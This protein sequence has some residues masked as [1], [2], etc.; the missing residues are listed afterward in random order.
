MG[1]AAS[2]VKISLI[3]LFYN[4][5]TAQHK[6]VSPGM[7]ENCCRALKKVV[8]KRRRVNFESH[9]LDGSRVGIS[10]PGIFDDDNLT[11]DKL[12]CLDFV[13]NLKFL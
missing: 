13:L 12:S 1:A 8:F 4:M 9:N 3:S 6:T 11:G 5:G 7:P 10:G 2:K